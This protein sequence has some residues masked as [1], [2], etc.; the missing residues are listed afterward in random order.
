MLAGYRERVNQNETT[1]LIYP[2]VLQST[3]NGVNLFLENGTVTQTVKT[4][5][6]VV[7]IPIIKRLQKVFKDQSQ[8]TMAS[9]SKRLLWGLSAYTFQ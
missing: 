8:Q 1:C 5:H 4:R 6:F 9:W 2:K 3:R 7:K